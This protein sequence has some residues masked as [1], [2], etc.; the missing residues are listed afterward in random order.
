MF[1]LQWE[2]KYE[3]SPK[4]IS[5]GLSYAEHLKQKQVKNRLPISKYINTDWRL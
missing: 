4:N 3:W 5:Q 1:I 2:M